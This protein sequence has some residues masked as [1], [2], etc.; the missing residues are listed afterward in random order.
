[1]CVLLG[2]NPKF[3]QHKKEAGLFHKDTTEREIATRIKPVLWKSGAAAGIIAEKWGLQNVESA[4]RE[5]LWF[6]SVDVNVDACV[7]D[8]RVNSY[9][10]EMD[11][12]LVLLIIFSE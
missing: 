12:G 3:L 7:C 11:K 8:F 5:V 2:Q 1:M 10:W 6:S 9:C 4:D